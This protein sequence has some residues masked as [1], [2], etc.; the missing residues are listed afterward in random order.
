VTGVLAAS[1]ACAFLALG[2]LY[3]PALRRAQPNAAIVDDVTRERSF[4]PDARLV[5]CEDPTRVA[6]ELLFE[7]RLVSLERCDLWA[8]AASSLPFLLLVR[9]AQRETLRTATRF[10]GEYRYVP[11]NVTTLRTLREGVRTDTLV[12][13]ANYSTSDPEGDRRMRKDRKRRVRERERPG[14]RGAGQT[15]IP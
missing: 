11:A 3:A 12:L 9:D 13:L 15:G 14:P 7:A 5:L 10:V 2:T 6:R 8:P 4:R 1:A